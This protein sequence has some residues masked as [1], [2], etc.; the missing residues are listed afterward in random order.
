MEF[1][2]N[3]ILG[4]IG[5]VIAGSIILGGIDQNLEITRWKQKSVWWVVFLINLFWPI[6]AIA[7]LDKKSHTK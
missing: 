4:I 5:W 3:I 2:V 1:F 6:V 7:Y